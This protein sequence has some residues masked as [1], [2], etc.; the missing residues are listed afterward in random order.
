MTA[1][2]EHDWF[3][4]PLPTNVV[5]GHG[6][7]LYSSFAFR[8]YRSSRPVGLSV[9]EATGLYHGTFFELGPNAELCI[10]HYCT[11]VGAI[12]CT[13]KRVIIK[14]YVFAA[15]EVVL[16]DSQFAIPGMPPPNGCTDDAIGTS[17]ASIVIDN[18]VWIGARAVLLEGAPA[19]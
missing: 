5:L 12:I 8:H 11:L 7:W 2:L 18:N 17:D 6:S 4:E 3:S 10:G 16:A 19:R 14:D 1:R 13:N 15:H 9:G